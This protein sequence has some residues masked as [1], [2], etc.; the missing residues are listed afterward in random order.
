MYETPYIPIKVYVWTSSKNKKL[1]I[2]DT[3]GAK[4]SEDH[5]LIQE[6]IYQDDN[7]ENAVNRIGTSLQNSTEFD[8]YAWA[9]NKPLW[10]SINSI[11]WNGYNV[12]PFKVSNVSSDQLKEPISYDF[13]MKE[14]FRYKVINVAFAKDVPK[15]I[16][17]YYFVDSK[18]LTIK[19][20]KQRGDQLRSLLALD[21]S[22]IEMMPEYYTRINYH[23][24][25]KKVILSDLFDTSTISKHIDMIQ[26]VNDR[27][28]ILYKLSKRNRIKKEFLSSWTNLDKI[29]RIQVLNLYSIY[30]KNSF[31]K[32]SIDEENIQINYILDV[33]Q[34]VKWKDIQKHKGIIVN[35]IQNILKQPLHLTELS[36]NVSLKINVQNSLFKLLGEKISKQ[37]DIFN[38]VKKENNNK[39]SIVCAYKRSSNYTQNT[40]IYDY[41]KS[42]I[43]LGI[44]KQEIAEE[45]IN[46]GITGNVAQM[47]NEEVE[48]MNKGI[49]IKEREVVKIKDNG[50]IVT[51]TPH[52]QGYNIA[53]INAANIA[54]MRYLFFWLL[55]LVSASINK[56]QAT[57][58]PVQT[59]VKKSSSSSH[60]ATS[61]ASSSLS[62]YN[63]S[64]GNP[65]IRKPK[66]NNNYL[67]SMLQ[68]T[69]R[70]LFSE[71]YAR[72]KCQSHVQPVV[73]S[74]EHK[75][76]LEKQGKMHFD[77]TIEYGSSPGNINVYACPKLWCPQSKTPLPLEPGAKCPLENEEPIKMYKD[78][79]KLKK[80]YVKLIKKNEKGMCVP[81]CGKNLQPQKVINS[82]MEYL[83]PNGDAPKPNDD[84][85]ESIGNDENYIM[86]HKAPIPIGRFGTLPEYLHSLLSIEEYKKCTGALNTKTLCFIRKGVQNTKQES[87]IYSIMDILKINNKKDLISNIKS[88]LDLV[89]FISLDNGNIAKAFSDI[90]KTNDNDDKLLKE[91][92]KFHKNKTISNL[93]VNN[94]SIAYILNIYKAYK[95]YL[96][97]LSSSDLPKNKDHKYIIPIIYEI[98]NIG[99][100]IWEKQGDEIYM[101][102]WHSAF[103]NKD[104]NPRFA[105]I[106]KEDK[107][108]EPIVLKK[109]SSEESHVFKIDDYPKLK[110]LVTKCNHRFDEDLI[111]NNIYIL[112]NLLPQVLENPKKFMIKTVLINDDLTINRVLT[113][114][115]ILLTFQ[116][117]GISYLSRFVNEIGIQHKDIIFY[118][119]IINETYTINVNKN[120]KKLFT[121]KAELMNI[122]V[123][124]G[125]AKIMKQEYTQVYSTLTIKDDD[126]L[127][128]SMILH[129]DTPNE[130]YSSL[131]DTEN[132]TKTWFRLQKMVAKMILKT[133]NDK[134]LSGDQQ[135]LREK[136]KQHFAN[137]PRQDII[138]VIL[139]EIPLDSI[140]SVKQW[141]SNTV[142]NAKYDYL[143]DDIREERKQFVFSQNIFSKNGIRNIPDVLTHYHKSL[144]NEIVED[145]NIEPFDINKAIIKNELSLPSIFTG[146]HKKLSTKWNKNKKSKLSDMVYIECEYTTQTIPEF[147]DWFIQLMKTLPTSYREIEQVASMEYFEIMNDHN[148]MYEILQDVSYFNEWQARGKR[149]NTVRLF[150]EKYFDKL[151][152]GEKIGIISDIL[153]SGKLYANDLIFKTISRILN[154]S[155][156]I[157][158]RGVY[159]KFNEQNARGGID[160][161]LH[162]SKLFKSNNLKDRPL[163]VFNKV[164]DKIRCA[165]YLVVEKQRPTTLYLNYNDI[166]VEIQEIIDKYN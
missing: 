69:D 157:I 1:Y 95:K 9:N 34:Y 130:M 80:S 26:W 146:N 114:D 121:E 63:S 89:K 115:N 59:I 159:G 72:N 131:K 19:Q 107:Y 88:K 127:P 137:V 25:L 46:L 108:Y 103:I 135:T 36:I 118:R 71:D 98:Y 96:D 42:R 166:P 61:S 94:K 165:Y 77:N 144:P 158:Q 67:I 83:N 79:D 133:F 39:Q 75:E 24:K 21:H 109:R 147:V 56:I 138:Q 64:G 16:H 105:M 155:V 152:D 53:I 14:L 104:L 102:C 120:D 50:T 149:H 57:K 124:M 145:K 33:R 125:D 78:G 44:T 68:Q 10:F 161:L 99:I 112:N 123:D 150:L 54:E 142:V 151:G 8:I 38:V 160:D 106:I 55:K 85:K 86:N 11:K 122:K 60:R 43:M 6:D 141:L 153:K 52:L 5:V 27:S 81:C 49:E 15:D 136:I 17:K 101:G 66:K 31:C 111:F 154:I 132:K 7:V 110:S 91:F 82:C 93:S 73:F 4:H 45:L 156:L 70:D 119:T 113:K 22:N 40:N 116:K 140:E 65:P 20:Y 117:I 30:N 3:S 47:I 35:I 58:K 84:E 162:S 76:L 28:K 92:N 2:F 129:Y 32:I 143:S 148:A 48:L 23:S 51:I 128:N 163:L 134:S 97:Y 18:K 126:V 90:S 100:I 13:T 87:I 37:I 12:N 29:D 139:E 164:C 74:R 41:I 62:S